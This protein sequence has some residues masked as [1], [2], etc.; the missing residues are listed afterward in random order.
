VIEALPALEPEPASP[1]PTYQPLPG[2]PHATSY[3]SGA[4]LY[5]ACGARVIARGVNKMNVWTDLD[6][7][8]SFAEIA[9]TG[10]N[11]VRI[12]WETWATASQLDTVIRNAVAQELIPMI[13]LHD[14]TGN[15]SLLSSLVDYWV[16]ADI[17]AVLIAHEQ[18]L[19]LNI[20][21]E[22]G[23]WN[24]TS[25]QFLDG[26]TQAIT[27][28]RDAGIS[29]PLVIDSRGWGHDIALIRQTG[30]TLIDTDPL[31]NIVFSTHQYEP[32][33][34]QAFYTSEFSSTTAAGIP[35]VVG[36]FGD[37]AWDC[38]TA[39]DYAI[40]IEMANAHDIGWYAW[41]WGPGNN[42][43]TSL[44]MTSNNT[45]EGLHGWGLEVAVTHPDSIQNTAT[46][47]LAVTAQG[48]LAPQ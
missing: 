36:E 9:R 24:V 20:G 30:P 12:V 26:Y 15:F 33:N 46:P 42:P 44:D 48:C 13:E 17:A 7:I 27:R 10:A 16:R 5:D 2:T 19:L 18:Y 23:S 14:A 11:S 34:D 38:K 28:I 4:A 39:V 47:S 32:S 45:Y 40:L 6:G 43:C 35:L 1:E 22:V 21:N 8:P 37:V 3:T 41:S 25:Q 29:M 31:H